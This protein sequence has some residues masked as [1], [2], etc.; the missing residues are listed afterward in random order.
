MSFEVAGILSATGIPSGRFF[1]KKVFNSSF[2]GSVVVRNSI[3]CCCVLN[4]EILT[5]G[6]GLSV[7]S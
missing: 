1:I 7:C 4:F 3:E 2:A 5:C 6:G